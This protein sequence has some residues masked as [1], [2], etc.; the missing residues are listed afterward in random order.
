MRPT[1]GEHWQHAVAKEIAI[2]SGVLVRWVFDPNQRMC[3][4]V[5]EQFCTRRIQQWPP[6][7]S[8][9]EGPGVAHRRQ[10]FA[11]RT[12]QQ[13]QQYCFGLVVAMMRQGKNFTGV[14]MF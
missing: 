8:R 5:V 13:S 2:Q 12:A 6:E 4:G 11:A 3:V 9:G 10:A 14:Q 1:F 7:F